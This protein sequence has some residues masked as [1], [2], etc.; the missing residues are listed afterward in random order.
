VLLDVGLYGLTSRIAEGI[1]VGN[2]GDTGQYRLSECR[3][4]DPRSESPRKL[5]HH[6][7]QAMRY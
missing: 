2:T 4:N 7:A 5:S 3:D 6:Y 1:R